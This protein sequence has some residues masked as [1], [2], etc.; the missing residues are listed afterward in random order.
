ME[1]GEAAADDDGQEL[2]AA[3]ALAGMAQ[4]VTVSQVRWYT[5]VVFGLLDKIIVIKY[6]LLSSREII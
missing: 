2:E 3:E 1:C 4:H 6:H 5:K